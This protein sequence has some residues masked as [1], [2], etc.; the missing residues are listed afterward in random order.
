MSQNEI[1]VYER[2]GGEDTFRQLVDIFYAKVEAD[3]ILRSIFP[4]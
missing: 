4:D 3:E 2:V 1:T